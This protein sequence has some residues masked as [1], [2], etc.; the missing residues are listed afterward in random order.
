LLIAAGWVVFAGALSLAIC[1]LLLFGFVLPATKKISANRPFRFVNIAEKPMV[2][3]DIQITI[4]I[5]AQWTPAEITVVLFACCRS[6]RCF[7]CFEFGR[8][9]AS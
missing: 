7:S 1:P 4:S 2:G 9:V 6:H 5:P 8:S 3:T